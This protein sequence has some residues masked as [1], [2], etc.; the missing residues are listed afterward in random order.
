MINWP[1]PERRY[2]TVIRGGSY[3]DEPGELRSGARRASHRRMN[4]RDTSS[5][6]QSPHWES[7][8]FWVGFRLVSPMSVPTDAE[9]QQF[10]N[11]DLQLT[12]K[13][14][15]RDKDRYEAIEPEK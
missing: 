6:G 8:N 9:K 13:R 7:E 3:E 12:R 1:K 11:P 2:N 5:P 10:W 14:M 15:M 4:V